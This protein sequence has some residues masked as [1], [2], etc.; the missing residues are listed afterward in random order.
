MI[1]NKTGLWRPR[2][3]TSKHYGSED[4][5]QDTEDED[6][7]DSTEEGNAEEEDYIAGKRGERNQCR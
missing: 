2:Y 7:E 1:M 5:Q 4:L 3:H 6:E